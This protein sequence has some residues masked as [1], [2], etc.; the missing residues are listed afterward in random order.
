M[1]VTVDKEDFVISVEHE[2]SIMR[3]I[4][5][6]ETMPEATK[7]C[8][9]P[10]HYKSGKGTAIPLSAFGASLKDGTVRKTCTECLEKSHHPRNRNSHSDLKVERKR[11]F[12]NE[13]VFSQGG[14]M[15]KW[16]VTIV[17]PTVVTVY[18]KD[19][20]SAGVEAGEGEIVHVRRLD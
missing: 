2:N 8:R 10:W 13:Q 4:Q 16:E 20:T 14:L 7:I 3:E 11:E 5:R 6:S 15:H 9:G 18:A 17:K 12:D 1:L 19:Y